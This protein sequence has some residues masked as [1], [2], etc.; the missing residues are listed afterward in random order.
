M[1]NWLAAL[2][3]RPEKPESPSDAQRAWTPNADADDL[4]YAYRLLLGREPDPNGAETYSRLIRARGLAPTRLADLF[5]SSAEFASRHDRSAVPTEVALDGYSIFVRP[6]DQDISRPI[7]E[8]KQYEPHVTRAVRELLHAG[9]TFVDVGANIG[10]FTALAA[11]LVGETGKV[12]AIEPMDK[13]LQLIYATV[14]RNRFR[15]VEVMPFAASEAAGLLPMTTGAATSNGQAVRNGAGLPTLFAQARRLDD[16]L[17]NLG[18]LDLLKID[19]EGLELL[20]LRGFAEGLAR[21]RPQI[22]TEFHP[23]CMR[24]NAGIEAGEYLAFLFGYAD[25]IEVM[26]DNGP[27]VA[28]ASAEDVLAEWRSADQRH[29][30]RGTA[31]IDLFVRPRRS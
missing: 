3:R 6:I 1:R 20:A 9:D 14:W 2:S 24:E 15:H 16:L 31:H 7:M 26:H 22:L 23:K 27:R 18:S 4:W 19:I 5:M 28:C 8:T 30:S 11:H 12:V 17:A 21:H 29:D 13:N 10:F 25:A